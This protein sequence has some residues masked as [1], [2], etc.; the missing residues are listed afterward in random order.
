[1][2]LWRPEAPDLELIFKNLFLFFGCHFLS[3]IS[4]KSYPPPSV[5]SPRNRLY[6]CTA[7]SSSL[8]DHKHKLSSI[9]WIHLPIWFFP[10]NL[11]IVYNQT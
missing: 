11:T 4:L 9:Q 10:R 8:G 2:G 6:K 7:C 3:F 5:L 1:M